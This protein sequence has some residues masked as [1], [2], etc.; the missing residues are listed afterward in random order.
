MVCEHKEIVLRSLQ[1]RY[2]DR[3]YEYDPESK[4]Y[5]FQNEAYDDDHEQIWLCTECDAELKAD[6]IV[7][8]SNSDY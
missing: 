6:D 5:I 4:Q 8:D 2:P 3:Y 7:V 1:R